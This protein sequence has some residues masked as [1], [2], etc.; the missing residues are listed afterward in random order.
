MHFVFTLLFTTHYSSFVEAV[1]P[2]GDPPAIPREAMHSRAAYSAVPPGTAANSMFTRETLANAGLPPPP[3]GS[4]S[5]DYGTEEEAWNL[6]LERHPRRATQIRHARAHPYSVNAHQTLLQLQGLPVPPPPSLNEM[7][8]LEAEFH[9]A[10][11]QLRATVD[12]A[13]TMQAETLQNRLLQ[14]HYSTTQRYVD[15]L[16]QIHGA[17]D[18][19][20]YGASE[21]LPHGRPYQVPPM[22]GRALPRI[23]I[24]D[25]TI[26]KAIR[27]NRLWRS[28]Q[29]CYQNGAFTGQSLR[30]LESTVGGL[31]AMEARLREMCTLEE[32]CDAGDASND[33]DGSTTAMDADET[34]ASNF[35]R[36]GLNLEDL[37]PAN[38]ESVLRGQTKLM[39]RGYYNVGTYDGTMRPPLLV[40]RDEPL[41]GDVGQDDPIT[42]AQLRRDAQRA[43]EMDDLEMEAPGMHL[44]LL[45]EEFV[46]DGMHREPLD[47]AGNVYRR[48]F[49]VY[50]EYNAGRRR[51]QNLHDRDDDGD[52]AGPAAY[53]YSVGYYAEG[54]EDP[55]EATEATPTYGGAEDLPGAYS[56]GTD[57]EDSRNAISLAQPDPS[58]ATV[59]PVL[60]MIGNRVAMDLGGPNSYP[61][62]RHRQQPQVH[63]NHPGFRPQIPSSQPARFYLT[64]RGMLFVL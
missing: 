48:Q 16:H 39:D 5:E 35:D 50:E 17:V 13:Q 51:G 28:I 63:P 25:R 2:G 29:V 11:Q 10:R 7:A 44:E 64:P 54:D 37:E 26:S 55:I 9:A 36:T 45:D 52:R 8:T 33:Q 23:P 57:G 56:V 61:D 43:L 58:Q 59:D 32:Q 20:D 38:R 18:T 3:L 49:N 60:E 4:M 12:A 24:A 30:T 1:E 42:E 40:S 6:L 14:D 34:A 21:A 46:P 27:H 47:E 31:P 15:Q 19:T 41:A 62:N 22:S 53:Y